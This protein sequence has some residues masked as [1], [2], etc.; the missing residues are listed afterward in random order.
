MIFNISI[1][2]FAETTNKDNKTITDGEWNEKGF[3]S[4]W[5]NPTPQADYVVRVGDIDNFGVGWK[6]TSQNFFGDNFEEIDPFSGKSTTGHYWGSGYDRNDNFKWEVINTN[7]PNGLDRI[8]TVSGYGVKPNTSGIGADGYSNRMSRIGNTLQKA[9]KVTPRD[10]NG[11]ININH[12]I[13]SILQESSTEK[14]GFQIKYAMLQMF[15]DDFQPNAGGA[16]AGGA[17]YQ[18]K[19]IDDDLR[20]TR[21]PELEDLIN[22]LNQTG[23]V[24]KLISFEIPSRYLD[25]LRNNN[26]LKINIDDPETGAGDG[27]AVDFVK[28][29][30]NPKEL[31]HEGSIT[32][33]VTDKNSNPIEKA[34]VEVNGRWKTFTD[35]NGTYKIDNVVSGLASVKSYKAGEYKEQTKPTDIV[36]KETKI[37]NFELEHIY[38]LNNLV[39]LDKKVGNNLGKDGEEEYEVTLDIKKN[40]KNENNGTLNLKDCVIEDEIADEFIIKSDSY[41]AVEFKNSKP[42]E[43]KVEMEQSGNILKCNFNNTGD[44]DGISISYKIK[45]ANNEIKPGRYPTSRKPAVLE[46]SAINDGN[47]RQKVQFP[48]VE[49]SLLEGIPNELISLQRN[50]KGQSNNIS[51]G[52]EFEVEYTINPQPI[53]VNKIENTNNKE[54]TLVI[55]TSGS[56]EEKING[57]SKLNIMKDVAKN[58]VGKFEKDSKVDIAL[59]EYNNEA[60]SLYSFDKL[61]KSRI[62]K[63]EKLTEGNIDEIAKHFNVIIRY[64]KANGYYY[65]Y[66]NNQYK[67]VYKV[68]DIINESIN[69]TIDSLSANGSTNIGDGLRRAYYMQQSDSDT[70]KYIIIMTDGKSESYSVNNNNN[71]MIQNG[72]PYKTYSTIYYSNGRIYDY[73]E[74]SRIYANTVAENLL[75]KS[76]IKTFVVGFGE[77]ANTSNQEIANS[78]K[79]SYFDTLNEEQIKEIYNK[80][81]KVVEANVSAE[82]SFDETIPGAQYIE[83]VT[84]EDGKHVVGNNSEW[85]TINEDRIT[86]SLKNINYTKQG[87]YFVAEPIKFS[88]KFKGKESCNLD[89]AVAKYTVNKNS[90]DKSE[91]KSFN[92]LPINITKTNNIIKQGIFVKD[93]KTNNYILGGTESVENKIKTNSINIVRTIKQSIGIMIKVN[94][95]DINI[96]I[97]ID[98]ENKD[99]K[100][101]DK[102]SKLNVHE[103]ND[104]V[105]SKEPVFT[106]LCKLNKI[107]N[108][109]FVGKD[110]NGKDFTFETGKTYIIEYIFVTDIKESNSISLVQIINKVKID[111]IEKG[112][113][114][115]DVKGLPKLE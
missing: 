44:N 24:G 69:A 74:K 14:G 59:I 90:K 50:I 104:G 19:F 112:K 58:F 28:L 30:I 54:I 91:E 47:I 38:N 100:L 36:D 114:K 20:E 71:F 85:L 77:G 6:W 79:G 95:S 96:E 25:L 18:V 93:N 41:K 105:I 57:K 97:E 27:Y 40:N 46:Y 70:D 113:L 45:R 98:T 51:Q 63:N 73:R 66:I 29:L 4:N 22:H 103:I 60:R 35:K 5:R 108:N 43:V 32:G 11:T 33:R 107:T 89:K 72:T 88:L 2:T 106:K 7:E 10:V 13:R 86:G 99:L 115:I 94:T 82:I 111:G 42:R 80:I 61:S 67:Q 102:G 81:A 92:K 75:G 55:D 65:L 12:N 23:P 9:P 34:Y 53:P 39:D 3:K 87:D 83:A 52:K 78:A 1:L 101:D 15:V 48:Q 8:I 16:V 64:D 31:V 37:L 26:D 110:I 68:S 49:V 17:I 76:A 21:I 56:M 84:R 62:D 109:D